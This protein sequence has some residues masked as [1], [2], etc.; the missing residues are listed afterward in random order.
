[1]DDWTRMHKAAL[2]ILLVG[3]LAG[4]LGSDPDP[5]PADLVLHGGRIWTG[6]QSQ[7]WAEAV[8]IRS[9]TLLAVGSD[10]Q[11]LAFSGD[12]T[13]VV[14]LAG[15]FAMPGLRDN[16]AHVLDVVAALPASQ[17]AAV[18]R[19]APFI[20]S[21]E[22]AEV[23][24]EQ[25]FATQL[26]YHGSRSVDAGLDEDGRNL[27]PA[28][29]YEDCGA[30]LVGE[31]VI[32][33]PSEELVASFKAAEDELARQGLTTVVE[34]QL[35]NMTHVAALLQMQED[36]VS[37]VRWQLRVVPGCY[38]LL[39]R[40]GLTPTSEGDWVRLVGVKLYTD[41]YLGAWIAALR[42]PYSDRPGWTGI[43]A[44]D[45][46]TLVYRVA[47]ARDRGLLVGTHA[48]GDASGQ[49]VLDAYSAAGLTADD[50]ATIEH[51]SVLDE[52]LVQRFADQGVI[53]S[54]QPSFATTDRVFAED[55][56]GP[57]RLDGVYAT[58]TM[59]DKGVH[60]VFSSDYP[61]E[62]IDPRWTLQRAVTRQEL[63]GSPPWQPE[64]AVTVAEAL[65]AMTWA[66]AFATREEADRGTLA[67]G[68]AADLVVLRENPFNADPSRLA[69]STV[70][71]TVTNGLV[72]FEGT[73]SYPPPVPWAEAA[74]Q[75]PE[76]SS[77]AEMAG[78]VGH[79]HRHSMPLDRH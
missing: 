41:G 24:H 14:D 75:P 11:A 3:L 69:S 18:L 57:A 79:G 51:A 78:A 36:G 61:I 76:R 42:E 8:A 59:F 17:V 70:L 6:E 9:G 5:L 15:A 74:V 49:Q 32:A 56:L 39:D 45:A 22:E 23:R 53:A 68:K 50:R 30:G 58:R 64:D 33:S 55:R 28:S 44:Y 20:E 65:R 35:R 31:G 46:D 10:E 73:S 27:G 67:V 37:K 2:A 43:R 4:C 1:L 77:H 34:A 19:P 71:L 63:D 60:V 40:L 62:V 12:G 16:H 26:V 52:A 66:Q 29:L 13:R 7:P 25:D 21:E 47:E 54:V 38:P 72:T 48:I